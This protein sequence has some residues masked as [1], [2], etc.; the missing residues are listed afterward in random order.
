M[1]VGEILDKNSKKIIGIVAGAILFYWALQNISTILI[2]F[3]IIIN[4]IA[5]LLFGLCIAFIL[6]IPMRMIEDKFFKKRPIRLRRAFS[7]LL[8]ILLA[9]AMIIL[10]MFIVIPEI[11][12]TFETLG[13]MIPDFIDS[14][15]VWVD[16]LSTK[17]PNLDMWLSSMELDWNNIKKSSISFLQSGATG[18]LNS[19]INIATSV[20]SGIYIFY[21]A[22]C[23]L[24]ISFSKRKI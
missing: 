23:S 16:Q 22:L 17:L 6:N 2:F 18:I 10:V 4:S 24:Y 15:K 21:W 14:V 11:R 3:Q 7:L 9:L 19:T 12:K 8:T 1:E 5:P 13:A 20:F